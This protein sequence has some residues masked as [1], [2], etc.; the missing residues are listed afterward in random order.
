MLTQ[1]DLETTKLFT[2]DGNDILKVTQT[3]T[4]E[5]V[6]LT[7]LETGR[8]RTCQVGAETA[9]IFHP[10]V[11]PK[12]ED[13]GQK[14]GVRGQKLQAKGRKQGKKKSPAKYKGVY[15]GKTTAGGEKRW[16]AS[17]TVKGKTIH[18]GSSFKS[19]ELAAAAVQDYIGNEAEAQKLRDLAEQ[20]EINVD[21]PV[22][23]RR[24]AKPRRPDSG[25]H[26]NDRTIV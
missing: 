6:F 23:K 22:D 1:K 8:V 2:T 16:H 17:Q 20:A 26:S 25:V 11:M 18:L 3:Q 14:T 15:A 5:Q 10:V 19:E 4:I 24:K 13:R 7:D 21:R 12:V 9:Q